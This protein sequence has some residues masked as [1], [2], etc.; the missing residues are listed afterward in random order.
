MALIMHPSTRPMTHYCPIDDETYGVE[1]YQN[2]FKYNRIERSYS[3]R[4]SSMGFNSPSPNI[5]LSSLN[6]S[7]EMVIEILKSQKFDQLIDICKLDSLALS[8]IANNE[9][10][11]Q[12]LSSY[13]NNFSS[14]PDQTISLLFNFAEYLFHL[15]DSHIKEEFTSELSLFFNE[16]LDYTLPSNM[17]SQS[18]LKLELAQ[19]SINLIK[20]MIQNSIFARDTLITCSEIHMILINICKRIPLLAS[21]CLSA[22]LA[23]FA[24]PEEMEAFVIEQT[25]DPI[26]EIFSLSISQDNC[27]RVILRLL[28]Q[29]MILLCNA[30]SIISELFYQKNLA[31]LVLNFLNDPD[32]CSLV[33]H[34]IG[35]LSLS[36]SAIESGFVNHDFILSMIQL[37]QH[38][39]ESTSIQHE[40][41]I[42]IVASVFWLF[43]QLLEKATPFCINCFTPE[44]MESSFGICEKYP[45]QVKKEISFFIVTFIVVSDTEKLLP[46]INE[47]SFEIFDEMICCGIHYIANRMI[48]ALFKIILKLCDSSL[49][50]TILSLIH[51]S[52]IPHDLMN[53]SNDNDIELLSQRASL[54][55]RKIESFSDHRSD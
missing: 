25:V 2:S 32:L 21:H 28:I 18:Q 15:S 4:R 7:P 30:R 20:N 45:F 27:N 22:L 46:L 51:E 16:F 10:I 17:E 55:A 29:I 36:E 19:Q 14:L 24:D 23:I 9:I 42:E 31:P 43:S 33:I 26:F 1:D 47:K 41:L 6:F 38:S 44:F 53:L 52:D 40:N 13:F 35:H 8:Q 39:M 5:D 3:L 11:W 37:L 48:D 54:L 12:I 34:L 50:P 49:F